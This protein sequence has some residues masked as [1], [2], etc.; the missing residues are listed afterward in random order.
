M[1]PG[2]PGWGLGVGLTIT[3]LKK[4]IGRKPV[5]WTRF[6]GSPLWRRRPAL[7]CSANEEEDY[8]IIS[9]IVNIIVFSP[10]ASTVLCQRRGRRRIP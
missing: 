6:G 5:M 1:G 3:P 8:I 9:I 10:K 4:L 7:G 2:P